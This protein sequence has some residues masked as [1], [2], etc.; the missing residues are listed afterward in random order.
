MSV[1][2]VYV[3]VTLQPE[4][5][6]NCGMVF[7]M[8]SVLMDRRRVDGKGFYC[9]NGHEQF[10]I[11]TKVKKLEKELA[12]EKQRKEWAEQSR[13][14]AMKRANKMERSRNAVS[15][16]LTRVK[17]RVAH[18]VCPCCNRTFGNVAKH[19]AT[20]HPDYATKVEA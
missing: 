14:A 10:Y 1:N 2:A 7:G 8:D 20:K 19:M 9:P 5:C 4:T 12:L 13:D 11:E 17:K 6:C 15:G 3:T 16:H 18:G